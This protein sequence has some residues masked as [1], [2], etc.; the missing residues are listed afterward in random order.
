MSFNTRES[1]DGAR[2]GGGDGD[3]DGDGDDETREGEGDEEGNVGGGLNRPISVYASRR[4]FACN[5]VWAFNLLPRS[6]AE[7]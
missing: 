7:C 1:G 2:A 5:S 3:G 4:R 6:R